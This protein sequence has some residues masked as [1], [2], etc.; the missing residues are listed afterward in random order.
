MQT[1]TVIC[2]QD[3]SLQKALKHFEFYDQEVYDFPES[4]NGPKGL[5]ELVHQMVEQKVDTIFITRYDMILNEL[6]ACVEQ[7]L[8][9]Y[10]DVDIHLYNDG[11]WSYYSFDNRGVISDNWPF[12]VLS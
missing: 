3:L 4:Q 11:D 9:S 5:R 6:G 12:G 1:I 10:L 7:G 2:G 8:I